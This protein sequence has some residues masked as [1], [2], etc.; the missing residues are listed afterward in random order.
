MKFIKA[1]GYEDGSETYLK[2]EIENDNPV[3]CCFGDVIWCDSN[4]LLISSYIDE[5]TLDE[6]AEENELPHSTHKAI[7][8]ALRRMEII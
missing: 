6:W 5:D 3:Y 4:T 8:G 7:K 2:F 1:L